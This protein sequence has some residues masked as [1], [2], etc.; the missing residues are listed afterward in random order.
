MKI[1]NEKL[2]IIDW[3]RSLENE[4]VIDHLKTLQKVP[5]PNQ[6]YQ[7]PEAEKQAVDIGLKSLAEERTY[8]NEEVNDIM[9]AKYPQLY[10]GK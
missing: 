6:I 7:L 3:I 1:E 5:F 10:K 8:T 4:T 9:R 2:K